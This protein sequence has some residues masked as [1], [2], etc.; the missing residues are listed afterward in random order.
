MTVLTISAL[1]PAFEDPVEETAGILKE[2]CSLTAAL[3]EQRA[4]RA[5]DAFKAR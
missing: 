2:Q 5:H 3:A 1:M 4:M